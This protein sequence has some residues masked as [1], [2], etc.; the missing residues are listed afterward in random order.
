MSAVVGGDE[1]AKP[2]SFNVVS[3]FWGGQ[4]PPRSKKPERVHANFLG[5]IALRMHKAFQ[6]A[7]VAL[8]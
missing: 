1:V 3:T 2:S 7:T 4:K 5:C 8:A 6:A